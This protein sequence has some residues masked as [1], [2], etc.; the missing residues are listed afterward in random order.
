MPSDI[1][2]CIMQFA[3]VESLKNI[4][5]ASNELN[6][7]ASGQLTFNVSGFG[8]IPKTRFHALS[9]KCNKVTALLMEVLQSG[10]VY[11]DLRGTKVTD[12]SM[13]GAVYT[14]NLSGTKVTD[15]SMLGAV[16]TLNLSRTNATDVS[17]LGAVHV[18][19]LSF[20]QVTDVSML[21]AVYT[22][23]LH[24]TKAANHSFI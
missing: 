17:M 10:R 19:D 15:V 13:L 6:A 11:V 2:W 9:I 21:G 7:I 23:N 8:S 4:R 12:V 22:L 24:G 18:L 14:L 20:T 16:H 5:L 1:M 3:D